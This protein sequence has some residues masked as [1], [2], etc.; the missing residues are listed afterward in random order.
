M[1]RRWEQCGLLPRPL[2]IDSGAAE[3]VMP[4][5]W[6]KG[7]SKEES[8]GSQDGTFYTTADGAAIY[9]KGQK[10]LKMSTPDGLRTRLMTFQLAKA[11]KALGSV[12]KTVSDGNR[13]VSDV[14]GSHIE[15]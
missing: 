3:T 13:A 15:N 4:S 1:R 11:S 6:L 5:D 7:H 14:G 10:T 9:K 12:S 2:A 8:A